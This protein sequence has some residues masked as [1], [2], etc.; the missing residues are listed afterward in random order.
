MCKG[1]PAYAATIM[2]ATATISRDRA[3][4][5]REACQAACHA[6]A[7]RHHTPKKICW[8]RRHHGRWRRAI[9]NQGQGK[10]EP[11][12]I[13]YPTEGTALDHSPAPFSRRAQSHAARLFF[14]G[15]TAVKRN[16]LLRAM[17]RQ[18]SPHSQ[19]V[20]KAGRPQVTDIK[21]S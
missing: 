6:V 5:Y 9:R 7:I 4:A 17:R 15:G 3:G 20:E 21:R 1:H 19:T 10:G 8:E 2:T 14:N 18:Y 13:V 12:E 16:Q 11:V